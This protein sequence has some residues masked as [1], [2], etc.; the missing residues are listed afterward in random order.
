MLNIGSDNQPGWYPYLSLWYEWSIV[1]SADLKKGRQ[2]HFA[3]DL[4]VSH[5]VAQPSCR[6]AQSYLWTS[7]TVN[8]RQVELNNS[9]SVKTKKTEAHDASKLV[10]KCLCRPRTHNEPMISQQLPAFCIAVAFR[11]LYNY[12][13]WLDGHFLNFS[14]LLS[15]LMLTV[16]I[17]GFHNFTVWSTLHQQTFYYDP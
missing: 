4:S 7:V 5:E 10:W 17:W 15:R 11:R 12:Q 9:T 2:L 13:Y 8:Y 1:A 6:Y 16:V 3:C 14:P